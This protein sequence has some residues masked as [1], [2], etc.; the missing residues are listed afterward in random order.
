MK[1]N[2]FIFL[3]FF[4]MSLNLFAIN[5]GSGLSTTGVYQINNASGSI[6]FLASGTLTITEIYEPGS[7]T[8]IFATPLPA[9]DIV[10]DQQ[11]SESPDGVRVQFSTLSSYKLI[12]QVKVDNISLTKF[13]DYDED[14]NSTSFTL[15]TAIATGTI[16]VVTYEK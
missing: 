14:G 6:I 1:R 4:I 7:S 16:L 13:I 9:V 11:P 2:I 15:S 5:F 8:F 12:W 3:Y 10:I